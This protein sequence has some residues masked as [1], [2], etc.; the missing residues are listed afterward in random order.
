MTHHEQKH[1]IKVSKYNR[2]PGYVQGGAKK[3]YWA[4]CSCGR[5]NGF[6][7]KRDAEEWVCPAKKGHDD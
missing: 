2:S 7:N 3:Y 5:Y 4:D 1:V 6:N